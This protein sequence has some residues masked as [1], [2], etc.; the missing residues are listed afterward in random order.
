MKIALI[1]GR[2]IE[3]VGNTK[4]AI[5]WSK[6]LT[7]K[8]IENKIF[9]IND[10]K[11]T[12]RKSMEFPV[13][14]FSC[15]HEY[16]VKSLRDNLNK[17]DLII[18]LSVPSKD[19]EEV[20]IEN[21]YNHLVKGITIKKVMIQVD[22]NKLS[23][24]RNGKLIEI[25]K[26]MDML[27]AHSDR[28]DFAKWINKELPEK[29]IYISPL[30]FNFDE[31]RQKYWKLIETQKDK[32]VK[33]IGRSAPWKG[34]SLFIDF[35]NMYFDDNWLFSMEGMELSLGSL[36]ILFNNGQRKEGFKSNL[37]NCIN[38]KFEYNMPKS[39]KIYLC[40]D[41]KYDE[42]MNR[43]SETAFGSDLY[44]LKEESYGYSAEYSQLDIVCSGCVPIFHSHFGV[45]C[46]NLITGTSHY[47]INKTLRENLILTG[48]L[49]LDD[50]NMNEVKQL[51]IELSENNNFRDDIREI[52]FNYWKNCSDGEVCYTY[53]IKQIEEKL[54][55]KIL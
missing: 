20:V 16:V 37:N 9:A 44:H 3:G 52:A 55:I 54:N 22:H 29:K 35:H 14:E 27:F 49:W 51:M 45:C 5:E 24:I 8:G 40:G 2:G 10:R 15:K 34:P 38:K 21:F 11:W 6:F 36:N 26:E 1:L 4:T 46:K 32:S 7:K 50:D 18:Y 53:T 47:D 23:L 48:T 42:C 33:F 19:N 17:F 25:S 28:G 13:I 41:Y 30:G 12:R 39:N 43:L 31:H